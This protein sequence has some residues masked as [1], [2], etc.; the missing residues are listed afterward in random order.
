LIFQI[1]LTISIIL[2]FKAIIWTSAAVWSSGLAH[3]SVVLKGPQFKSGWQTEV[4]NIS[5]FIKSHS[6]RSFTR[7]FLQL[8]SYMIYLP[9]LKIRSSFI[10]LLK[11]S[12][13][14]TVVVSLLPSKKRP[15]GQKNMYNNIF[16]PINN[17]Q[18]VL[19]QTYFIKYWSIFSQK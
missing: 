14:P 10:K 16:K 12:G 4:R 19:N 1:I 17:F 15:T 7:L 2:H 3:M 9:P 18:N 5:Y 11:R 6:F 8:C 13:P